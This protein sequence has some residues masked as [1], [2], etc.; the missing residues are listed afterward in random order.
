[1][2]FFVSTNA[3]S[4]ED[5]CCETQL[6]NNSRSFLPVL[7]GLC[8]MTIMFCFMGFWDKKECLMSFDL[9]NEVFLPTLLPSDV[10][11]TPDSFLY[12]YFD[13]HLMVLNGIYTTICHISIL[14][15]VGVWKS[16][17]KLFKVEPLP[18]I[19]YLAGAGKRGDIFFRKRDSELAWFDLSAQKIEELGFKKGK[20]AI[21]EW[22]LLP[23]GGINN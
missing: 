15:E 16:W 19:D 8:L 12:R 17:I 3:S 18:F 9:S 1:M 4:V 13:R 6:L 2:E 20:I 11:N 14:G 5:M 10:K 22:S 7:L 21:Y 23:M